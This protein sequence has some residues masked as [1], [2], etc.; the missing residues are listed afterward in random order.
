MHVTISWRLMIFSSEQAMKTGD[1]LSLDIF[2]HFS[3]TFSW[4]RRRNIHVIGNNRLT[5]Y[6]VSSNWRLFVEQ[7]CQTA[8]EC[9]LPLTRTQTVLSLSIL[10]QKIDTYLE[11]FDSGGPLKKAATQAIR[12]LLAPTGQATHEAITTQSHCY[13]LINTTC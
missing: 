7:M 3:D 2:S 13:C 10:T 1:F 8:E 6:E 9:K 12:L 4:N 5:D 11:N